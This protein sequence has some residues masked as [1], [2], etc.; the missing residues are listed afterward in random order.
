MRHIKDFSDE[1]DRYDQDGD[2]FMQF[3]DFK[4]KVKSSVYY[5]DEN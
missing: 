5:I 1:F 2:K 3:A 4:E